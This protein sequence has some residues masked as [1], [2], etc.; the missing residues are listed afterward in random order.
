VDTSQTAVEDA[1]GGH[2]LV[3]DL[4]GAELADEFGEKYSRKEPSW[5]VMTGRSK[6]GDWEKVRNCKFTV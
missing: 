5:P 2:S 3:I 1:G 4:G 6:A